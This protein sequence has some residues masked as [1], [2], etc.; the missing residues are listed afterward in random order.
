MRAKFKVQSIA[1]HEGGG[2]SAKMY[3][4]SD[5]GTEENRR[6]HK[7]TPSGSV[8]LWIDNPA[9]QGFLEIGKSYYVDFTPAE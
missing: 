4:V 3:A 8:E 2:Y 7:A 1:R 6:F 5:D 9:A